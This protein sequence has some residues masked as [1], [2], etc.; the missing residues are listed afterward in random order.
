MTFVELLDKHFVGIA[1]LI[2]VCITVVSGA[3]INRKG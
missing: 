3:F 2:V 1:V